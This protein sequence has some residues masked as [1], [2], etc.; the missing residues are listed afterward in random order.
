MTLKTYIVT[1]S[2]E[3]PA[4]RELV[5]SLD[6]TTFAGRAH[7]ALT[8]RE[9]I[10]ADHAIEMNHVGVWE[11]NEF[12]DYMNDEYEDTLKDEFITAITTLY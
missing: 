5:E 4:A 3:Y 7:S 2:T 8:L 11:I 6:A 1:I 12:C 9:A 10:V